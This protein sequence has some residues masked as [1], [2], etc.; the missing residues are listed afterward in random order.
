MD[1]DVQQNDLWLA[2]MMQTRITSLR[3]QPDGGHL[4]LYL[5]YLLSGTHLE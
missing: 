1:T 4:F 5:R 2:R 3:E